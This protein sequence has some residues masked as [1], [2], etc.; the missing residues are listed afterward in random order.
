[1]TLS[2]LIVGLG[3]A[4]GGMAR[5]WISGAVSERAS[6]VF[7]WG[8]LVV[9]VVGSFLIGLIAVLTAPEG[10]LMVGGSARAFAMLGFL[11][12]FTTF[13]SFSLNTLNL[14]MDGEWL[15][16]G[17]NVAGSVLSCLIAVWLG[18]G[19]GQILNR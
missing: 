2:I 16:A 13:S 15:Y 17:L 8:T 9:N 7:P 6:S 14:A 10:R 19:C 12:G 3:S 18:Y 5:Y 4:L 1:M 11:G